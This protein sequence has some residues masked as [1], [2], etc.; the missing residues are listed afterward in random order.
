MAQGTVLKWILDVAATAL[1]PLFKALT[2]SIR[3][4][5][6]EKVRELWVKAQATPSV[7]DDIGV[8]ALAKL[9]GISLDNSPLS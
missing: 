2:K 5:L 1:A 4:E 9:I 8:A 7:F 6:D 3:D